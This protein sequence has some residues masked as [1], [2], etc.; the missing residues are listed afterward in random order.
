M[1][2][3]LEGKKDDPIIPSLPLCFPPMYLDLSDHK[4]NSDITQSISEQVRKD[5]YGVKYIHNG[6]FPRLDNS[7][8]GSTTPSKLY[9]T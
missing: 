6:K 1:Y 7:G 2:L 8:Q 4:I 9:S 5:V 3:Q